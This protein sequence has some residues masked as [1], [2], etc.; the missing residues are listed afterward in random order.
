MSGVEIGGYNYVN[1]LPPF[2]PF[3]TS[4]LFRLGFVSE[5]SIFITSGI[6]FFIG[7][8]GFF[9]LLRLRYNNFYSFFGAFL[10]STLSINI[11]WV[12]N[13]TL[14]IAF[15]ALMI[16]AL[17]FFIQGMEKNQ[18][19]FYIA[20]PLGVLSFFTKYTGALIF[21]VMLLYF[22]S[23]TNIATN[24]MKYFKNILGA[25]IAGII[26]SIPFFAYFFLNNIPL[27]FINQAS[28]VSSESSLTTTHAGH[29]VGNNLFFYISGI[30]YSISS[31]DYII[32]ILLVLVVSIGVIL[33]IYLLINYPEQ[34]YSEIRKNIDINDFKSIRNQAI[35]KKLYEELEKGNSNINN[36]IDWFEEEETIN[37]LSWI[38][39]YD[40][41]I[42]EVNK[43][44][45][46]LIN[47]YSKE[48]MLKQRNEIIRQLERTDLQKEESA[49]L[50]KMLN[51]IIIKLAKM[52]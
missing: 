10:Y 41:E 3:L 22:M 44:I 32:G 13:G 9:Y 1:Y 47:I 45:K 27:G 8:I 51:E 35:V 50:E 38:L 46:D 25:I 6:F 30:V 17:Y 26:T 4:L 33:I 14:D 18:K 24:I 34:S 39:A 48:N 7:I 40:F 12:A 31:T 11:K 52:K 23:R 5:V 20:F 28:Q 29:L 15:V 42:T 2:I 36:V 21:A 16:W 19:Y 49:E 43:C 37:Y